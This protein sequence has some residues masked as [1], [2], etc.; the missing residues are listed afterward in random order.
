MKLKNHPEEFVLGKFADEIA[1]RIT[2]KTISGLQ[3][4]KETLSGDDSELNN[5][6]DEICVQVQ[7]EHSFFWDAYDETA[8]SY[9]MGYI[10][11]L[12]EHEK[13]ALWFQTEIGWDWLYADDEEREEYPPMLDE[14]I[15]QYIVKEYLYRKADVWT[16][17]RI[18][19]YLTYR[20]VL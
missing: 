15:A 3:N 6:W 16:N 1:G 19:A 11:G 7:H 17:E 10:E 9:A 12:K 4:I 13:L 5:C 8:Q 20:G 18:R 2:R 14:D